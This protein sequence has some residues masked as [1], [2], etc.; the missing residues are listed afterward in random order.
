MI[1][2]ASI[3]RIEGNFAVC[4]IE[5]IEIEKSKTTDY[6]EKET[7]M[8]DVSLEEIQRSVGEVYEGDI[9]VVE[10]NGTNV[11]CIYY[12]D[13]EEKQRRIDCPKEILGK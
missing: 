10:H 12:K 2:Y 13:N 7:E 6:F 9:I 8:I 4:E 5:K 1:S 3:D 11:I